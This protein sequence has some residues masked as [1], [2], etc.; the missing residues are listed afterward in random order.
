MIQLS[1]SLSAN[2]LAAKLDKLHR[3]IECWLKQL[4]LQNKIEFQGV[5]KQAGIMKNR[6]LKLNQTRIDV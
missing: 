1:P 2:Q 4:K 6:I 3:T 5:P